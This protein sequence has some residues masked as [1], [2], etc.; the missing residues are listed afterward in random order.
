MNRVQIKSLL[1]EH[2]PDKMV[3]QEANKVQLGKSPFKLRRLAGTSLDFAFSV[4]MLGRPTNLRMLKFMMPGFG[5][6]KDKGV[7]AVAELLQSMYPENGKGA[8]L[9]QT[10]ELARP[11]ERYHLEEKVG[12]EVIRIERPETA[13]SLDVLFITVR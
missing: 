5:P 8:W 12:L 3:F 2:Y 4:E 7:T 11:G 10:A 9:R 6:A 1:A 13:D